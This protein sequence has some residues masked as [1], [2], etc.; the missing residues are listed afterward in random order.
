MENKTIENNKLIAEFMGSKFINDPYKANKDDVQLTDFWHWSKPENGWPRDM[1][2]DTC[3]EMSTAF[4]IANFS[5]H[6]SW[7]WLMPVVEKIESL[8]FRVDLTSGY[9]RITQDHIEIL[10][11]TIIHEDESKLQACYNSLSDFIKWFNTKSK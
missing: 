8:N 6:K 2:I 10:H 4:M 1:N 11:R 9:I 3:H 7:D 5:Y